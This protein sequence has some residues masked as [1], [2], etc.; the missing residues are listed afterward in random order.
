MR[1]HICR[2]L[3]P[4]TWFNLSLGHAQPIAPILPPDAIQSYVARFNQLDH[5]HFGQALTNE[6]TARWMEENVPRFECPDKEL[7]EI[8]HF[9]WW[10]FRKHIK[11]TPDG[12]VITEFLP[13]VSWSGKHNTISC[14][15]GHHFREGRWIRNPQ[16]LN[17]Y[18]SFWFRKEGNPR[19]Y[20][21]WAADSIYQRAI[22]LGDFNQAIDLLPDLTA[23]YQEWEK[24]RLSPDGL[25]WQIDD[26]DGMEVSI[27]GS[28]KRATI[29]SYMYGDA[30]AIAAMAKIAGKKD[31]ESDYTAKAEKIRELVQ[32]KLWDPEAH[33]FKTL[34]REENA[35]SLVDVR[36]LHGFTPWYFNLPE[37]NQGY[38]IAWQQLTAPKGFK[39]P[40]GPTSAEQR[41]PKFAISYQGHECQWN[42]PS[43]PFA[44]SI[45][46]TALANVLNDYRQQDISR[47][48]Y[49]ETLMT[50]AKSHRLTRDD[51]TVVP[52]I[53]ENL[54]PTT[55]DWISRTRLK[56]WKDGTWD[57][58]KGGIERGKD[59]NHST[60]CDLIITGLIGLRPRADN[61]IEINPLIPEGKWEYFC[62]DQIPYHGQ[63][64]TILYD[65]TGNRYNKGVGLRVYANGTEIGSSPTLQKLVTILVQCME[66]KSGKED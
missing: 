8:Y 65:K 61:Q 56:S 19:S 2:L 12:F 42:G 34:P 10:T 32:Q 22:T 57:A 16:Y 7:E 59:Y 14:P 21:F 43:W 63:L 64:L 58:G 3:F 35:T 39:A 33:F 9:R 6:T 44:T 62:L 13:K 31:V 27:G 55:G 29:N 47:D 17:D 15:A 37:P 11:E 46:L 49:F 25:F 1:R 26:R 41:H 4:I 23:N 45:T 5:T 28:G 52:W 66:I 18:A 50:Y 38:E 24:Q 36:E 54:N 20:S 40:Y 51:G 53:D 60:F 48:A 30:R